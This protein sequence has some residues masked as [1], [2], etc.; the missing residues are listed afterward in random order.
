V[1]QVVLDV[2]YQAAV[3]ADNPLH[4]W[5]LNEGPGALRSYDWGTSK[6]H[7]TTDSYG[8]VIQSSVN[9]APA[10]APLASGF[11]WQGVTADGGGYSCNAPGLAALGNSSGAADPALAFPV[12]GAI[13]FWT[14]SPGL[15]QSTW[16]GYF[17]PGNPTNQKNFGVSRLFG[18]ASL[19]AFTATS[20]GSF[21]VA[22][23]MLYHHI[24]Y[25][26]DATT[27]AA[28]V[29][30]TSVLT[31]TFSVTFSGG[32]NV[33]FLIGAPSPSNV[34]A[35]NNGLVSEVAVYGSKLTLTQAQTHRAQAELL[36]VFPQWK[37]ITIPA[38]TPPV[39]GVLNTVNHLGL[40]GTGQ[41]A[42]TDNYAFSLA[43]TTLPGSYGSSVDT[44]TF[45]FD[46]GF[47]SALT[48]N[49]VTAEYRVTRANQFAVLP[50][51]CSALS[52]SL[53][54]GIEITLSEYQAIT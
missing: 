34:T 47:V 19:F 39:T 17:A 20:P 51:F 18:S 33:H 49:G 7:L 15:S 28:Y 4:Y 42:L 37:G 52:W 27:F 43:I 54:P 14:L 12:P 9:L 36:N 13:E 38:G 46:L 3:L 31:G 50:P 8:Q 16:C 29:D 2:T 41:F 32:A 30:G 53:A 1:D 45:H 26:W 44:P 11:G 23:D 48:A 25:A 6:H 35:Q 24:V 5:R 40:S 10:L 22:S 21:L